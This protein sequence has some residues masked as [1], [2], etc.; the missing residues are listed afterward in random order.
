M[1]A[2]SGRSKRFL[3]R[4]GLLDDR[5]TF[6]AAWFVTLGPTRRFTTGFGD[7]SRSTDMQEFSDGDTLV[8]QGL[9]EGFS[10]DITALFTA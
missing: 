8:S 1:S 2:N 4:F 7:L 10:L 5:I 6:S 3:T 9:L